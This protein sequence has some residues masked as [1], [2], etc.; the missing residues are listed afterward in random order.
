M[1]MGLPGGGVPPG[2]PNPDPISDQKMSFSHSFSDLQNPYPLLDLASKKLCHHYLDWNTKKKRFLN[3]H[4]SLSFLLIWNWKDKYVHTLPLSPRKPYPIPDQNGQS[5]YHFSDQNST[6]TLFF[7]AAHT[8]IAYIGEYPLPPTGTIHFWAEKYDLA[9]ALAKKN[10][11]YKTAMSQPSL[12][13]IVRE[14]EELIW[15]INNIMI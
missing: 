9:P 4:I 5:L 14:K 15:L 3:S 6:K 12:K 10:K 7:G 11:K 13:N 1:G 2:S 8:Y